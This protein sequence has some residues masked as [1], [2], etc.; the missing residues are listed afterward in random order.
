MYLKTFEIWNADFQ[1]FKIFNFLLKGKIWKVWK[2]ENLRFLV[3]QDFL[4]I[5]KIEKYWNLKMRIFKFSK[6]SNFCL[7]EKIEKFQKL[8]ILDYL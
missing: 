7:K 6:L 3:D 1:I 4:K 2:F 5:E 8:K